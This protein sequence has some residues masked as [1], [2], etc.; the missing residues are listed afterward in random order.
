MIEDIRN[1]KS[2]KS[3]LRKFGIT[4]GIILVM[5]S[6]FLFWKEKDLF[7]IFFTMGAV[8]FIFGSILPVFLKPIHWIWMIFATILGQFMTHV[9]LSLIFYMIITPIGIFSRLFGKK[10]LSLRMDKTYSTYWNYHQ[11]IVFERKN[12]EKQ[13]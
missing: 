3:N 10:F 2:E 12:Y 6:G 5:I 1:L 9:V 11:R 7:Q 4:I 13:F 8:L